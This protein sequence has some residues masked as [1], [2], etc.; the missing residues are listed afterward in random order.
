MT[1]FVIEA[2]S[3]STC[4]RDFSLLKQGPVS[5]LDVSRQICRF[6]NIKPKTTDLTPYNTVVAVIY[7]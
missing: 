5:F 3:M 4:G 6:K 7:L 2:T 1:Q